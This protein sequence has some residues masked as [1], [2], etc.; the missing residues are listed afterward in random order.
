M[1]YCGKCLWFDDCAGSFDMEMYD[2][3]CVYYTDDDFNQTEEY[4]ENLRERFE[5]YQ[6]IVMEM[7]G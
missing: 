4:E 7:E 6:L 3:A 2:E 5:E 1:K